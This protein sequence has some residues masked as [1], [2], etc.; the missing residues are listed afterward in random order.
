MFKMCFSTPLLLVS[1]RTN[2]DVRNLLGIRHR[3]FMSTIQRNHIVNPNSL[4]MDTCLNSRFTFIADGPHPETF[5]TSILPQ[6][7]PYIHSLVV[8]QEHSQSTKKDRIPVFAHLLPELFPGLRTIA[9]ET[10]Y[11]LK[12]VTQEM[13]HML[14]GIEPPG[15]KYSPK[16]QLVLACDMLASKK[17]DVVLVFFQKP[18]TA[19][20]LYM[21]YLYRY[22]EHKLSTWFQAEYLKNFEFFDESPDSI[23]RRNGITS[24]SDLPNVVT[25][26]RRTVARH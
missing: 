5:W 2:A 3:V 18:T 14:P 9:F 15:T 11:S 23:Y 12:E 26:R 8:R 16:H 6:M 21:H 19:F 10:P 7:Q 13:S 24:F 4:F 22:L 20:L 17:V 25:I 1:K